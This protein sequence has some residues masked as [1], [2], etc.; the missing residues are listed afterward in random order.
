MI[1]KVT[2]LFIIASCFYSCSNSGQVKDLSHANFE[3][4]KTQYTKMLENIGQ[5]DNNPRTIDKNGDIKLVKS[6]DWTSGFFPGGLWYL[7][8]YTND[9]KMA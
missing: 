2:V 7:Y 4:A 9:D 3:R 6:K 5:S 8:E 1:K